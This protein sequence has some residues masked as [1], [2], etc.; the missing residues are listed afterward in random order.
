MGKYIVDLKGFPMLSLC[1][2]SSRTMIGKQIKICLRLNFER[3][4]TLNLNLFALYDLGLHLAIV[5]S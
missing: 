1:S 3:Q 4:V 2:G 5:Q